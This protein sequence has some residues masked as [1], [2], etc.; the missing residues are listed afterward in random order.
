MTTSTLKGY[1]DR[2]LIV[3]LLDILKLMELGAAFCAA[4]FA[5]LAFARATNSLRATLTCSALNLVLSLVFLRQFGLAGD[6]QYYDLSART[7]VAYWSGSGSDPVGLVITTGKSSITLLVAITYYLFYAEPAIPLVFFALS[8]GTLPGLAAMATRKFGFSQ[9]ATLAAWIA[10]LTPQIVLWSPWLR[11]EGLSF[12]LLA[13]GLVVISSVYS[14]SYVLA[15][16]LGTPLFVSM[17]FTR[18]ALCL[19][20][21]CGV[22]SAIVLPTPRRKQ[23]INTSAGLRFVGRGI[24][25]ACLAAGLWACIRVSDMAYMTVPQNREVIIRSNADVA[26]GLAVPNATTLLTG[27]DL[28]I[29]RVLL[30]GIGNSLQSLF[31]PFPRDWSGL[32]WVIAGLDGLI[33]FA[34]VGILIHSLISGPNT[35]R[36]IAISMVSCA[37]LALGNAY[38][39]ANF[40][41]V[42]RVRAHELVILVP[43]IAIAST[44]LSK[45]WAHF[46]VDRKCRKNSVESSG[47]ALEGQ[48]ISGADHGSSNA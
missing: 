15:L 27:S 39:L 38:M 3:N 11:R 34:V 13:V 22:A 24:V 4:F 36:V 1:R 16:T 25:I 46:S 31:G 6:A 32:N 33:F 47:G 28:G 12:V 14:R 18:T 42:M 10:A 41:I 21:I 17:F 48:V 19:V 44:T 35:R 29:P 8:A 7:L 40:G 43:A 5:L 2:P 26:Q 23:M 9:T 37:P 30:K 45:I 20:L